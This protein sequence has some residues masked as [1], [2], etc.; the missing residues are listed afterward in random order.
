MFEN[1]VFEFIFAVL[2][3][4]IV[5]FVVVDVVGNI[6]IFLSLTSGMPFRRRKEV[7]RQAVVVSSLLLIIF[8]VIG[9]FLLSI[10]GISLMSFKVAGGILLFIISMSI[11]VRGIWKEEELDPASTGVVP[12]AFPLLTGPGAITTAIISGKQYGIFVIILSVL[13]VSFINYFVL[14]NIYK[15][16]K[17]MGKTGSVVVSRLMSVFIASIAIDY[18]IEGIRSILSE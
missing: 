1:S 10:F 18:I 7:F 11:L 14:A 9:E 4:S 2:R 16:S 3:V 6:P 15:I 13:L 5:L 8:S 17:F 12:I